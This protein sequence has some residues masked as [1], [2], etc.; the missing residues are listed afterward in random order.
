MITF[1]IL[2]TECPYCN[3][4]Q[5][6]RLESFPQWWATC[7]DEGIGGCGKLF[8]YKVVGTPR[9]ITRKVEGEER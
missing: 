4:I 2:E 6:V 7:C 8:I 3:M 5:K 1:D 9:I